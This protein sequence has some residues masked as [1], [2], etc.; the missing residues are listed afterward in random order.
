[1][2]FTGLFWF[3]LMFLPLVIVQ[4]LLHRE[5]LAILPV[6]TRSSQLTMGLVSVLFLPG[7]F[8]HELSHFLMAKTLRVPTRDFSLFP[9]P[10]SDG[11]L[12]MGCVET[13]GTDIRR[14][15]LIGPAP[16]IAGTLFIA[17]AGFYH[18]QIST[19]LEILEN[20]QT[21]LFSMGMGVLPRVKDFFLWFYL[22]FAVSSKMLPSESDRHDWLPLGL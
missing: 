6:P 13:E 20:G 9:H 18:L 19:L 7:V 8:L 4:R 5:I 12:Q 10:L 3:L 21:E 22:A 1:V 14:D 17:H 2:P 15:S 11:R 16:L